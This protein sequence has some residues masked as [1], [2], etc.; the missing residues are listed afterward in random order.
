MD[1]YEAALNTLIARNLAYRCFRTRKEVAEAIA[2]APHGETTETFR[3]EALPEDD[4]RARL[5]A[6]ES[7]AWR[8]SLKKARAALGAAY[9]TLV[10]EDERGLVRAEPERHG[11]VVLAR[12]DF[13]TSYHLA[14]VLDD[15]RQGVTHVI[16]GEDL[17]EAA[18][19]HVLLQ[20]LLALPTPIYRHHRLIL[21]P[22]GKRLAKRDHAA[23]LR[24]LR[25]AGETPDSVR[26]MVGLGANQSG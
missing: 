20:R 5:E 25:E 13:A 24:A 15:A 17:R 11:D 12:K 1:E 22:D 9:F 21:G 14:S 10:F 4:E 7:F 23:T 16:R 26:A 18:H 2:S 19:L 3:G 6:G 8:L